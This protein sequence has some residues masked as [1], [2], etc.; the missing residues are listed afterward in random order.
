MTLPIP[1]GSPARETPAAIRDPRA[2][3]SGLEPAELESWLV[4]RGEPAWRAR[5]LLDAVWRGSAASIDDVRT[6]PATL[7]AAAGE[8]FRF[9]TLAETDV[10]ISDGGLT[11]KAL[12]RLSDG[13]LIE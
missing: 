5:Q 12:H 1:R 13:A 7:R 6:L 4:G 9:D 3:L 8:A 11:E 10:R 2:G